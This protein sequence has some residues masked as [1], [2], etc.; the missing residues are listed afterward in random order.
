[1]VAAVALLEFLRLDV[2]KQRLD[3]IKKDNFLNSILWQKGLNKSPD[4]P[5]ARGIDNEVLIGKSARVQGQL[6]QTGVNPG[7]GY[8]ADIH[9]VEIYD[10]DILL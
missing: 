8:L 7:I 5:N 4:G 10:D 9:V 6:G 2:L 3:I 1:M